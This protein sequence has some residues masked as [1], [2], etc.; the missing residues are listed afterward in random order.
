M[1]TTVTLLEVRNGP[2]PMIPEPAMQ[3]PSVYLYGASGS[4]KTRISQALA[5]RLGLG[6]IVD[7][8]KPKAVGSFMTLP[9]GVLYI[10]ESAMDCR[11]PMLSITQAK[12]LLGLA[13]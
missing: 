12:H 8:F 11:Q 5:T 10:A 1:I 13:D 4:G 2:Y 6:L 3:H 9:K 7:E